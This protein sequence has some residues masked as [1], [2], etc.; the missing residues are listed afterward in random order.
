MMMCHSY[1]RLA[2]L[3]ACGLPTLARTVPAQDARDA[4]RARV[5]RERSRIETAAAAFFDSARTTNQRLEAV[6]DVQAFITMQQASRALRLARNPGESLALRVRAVQLAGV[7]EQADTNFVTQMGSI[8]RDRSLPVE[9]RGESVRQ[10]AAASFDLNGKPPSQLEAL[11]VAVG[12]PDI[13]VRRVAFRALAGHA[14]SAAIRLLVDGLENPAAALLPTAEAVEL[15]ALKDPSPHYALLHRVLMQSTDSVV[16]AVTIQ[17]LGKYAPSHAIIAQHFRDAR[18]PLLVRR[19]ALGALAVG[20]RA[21]VAAESLPVVTDETAP[22]ELRVR[23]IRLV[24]L[25]RT[26]RDPRVFARSADA[27]DQAM[28]RLVASSTTPSVR[29]AARTYLTRTR[30]AR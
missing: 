10:L 15:V 22:P 29:D 26:S 16:T 17:A 13:E 8:A 27:F 4:E 24:E 19:A 5:E 23:A 30:T 2:L 18:Q 11:R 1:I 6:R 28:S 9:L 7:P 20:D 25:T 21:G 3:I 12:D 14:D